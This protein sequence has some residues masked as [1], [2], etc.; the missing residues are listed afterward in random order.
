MIKTG[1]ILG[2]F[3]SG[4]TIILGAFG[5]HGLEDALLDKIDVFETG[6][7]YHMF[8]AFSIIILGILSK[9]FGIKIR[10]IA[11]LFISGILIF[12]GSLYLISIFKYS[13]LGMITPIGGCC[14]ILGWVLLIYQL[15]RIK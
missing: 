8:H 7:Q 3:F 15:N 9:I 10:K 2:A 11:Y 6:I 13:F 1:I 4:L 12:S 5:A 14:F